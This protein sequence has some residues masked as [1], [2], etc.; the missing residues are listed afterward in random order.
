MRR[1]KRLEIDGGR[2][3]V[4]V[5]C[6]WRCLRRLLSM[7]AGGGVMQQL[8]TQSRVGRRRQQLPRYHCLCCEIIHSAT[9]GAHRRASPVDARLPWALPLAATARL[10]HNVTRARPLAVPPLIARAASIARLPPPRRPPALC[11]CHMLLR[12][13]CCLERSVALTLPLCVQPH[14]DARSPPPAP[15]SARLDWPPTDPGG[16][17]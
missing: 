17:R 6:V 13:H 14:R 7:A 16:E 1:V 12:R 15:V 2:G 5:V 8:C 9:Q 3:G 10:L 11:C 4:R